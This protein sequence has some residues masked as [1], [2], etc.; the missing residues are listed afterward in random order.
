MASQRQHCN[1]YAAVMTKLD[2]IQCVKGII[3]YAVFK[4]GCGVRGD[5]MMTFLYDSMMKEC[6][7]VLDEMKPRVKCVMWN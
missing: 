5:T 2:R 1:Q 6:D 7:T 4:A 3:H